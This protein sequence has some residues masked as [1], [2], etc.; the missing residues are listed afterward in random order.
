[1]PKLKEQLDAMVAQEVIKPVDEPTEWCEPI[2]LAGKPNGKIRICVDLSRLKMSG[3]TLPEMHVCYLTRSQWGMSHGFIFIFA[4]KKEEHDETLRE[5][6]GHLKNSGITLNKEKCQFGVSNVTFLG[7]YINEHSIKSDKKKVKAITE[8]KLSADLQGVQHFMGIVNFLG[9]FVPNLAEITKPL[10]DLRKK[11]VLASDRVLA[12]FDISKKTIISA[13]SSSYGLGAVL[14]QEH[15]A[16]EWRPMAFASRTLTKT[17]QGYT[18]IEKEA[19]P[20]TWVCERFKDFVV[21]KNLPHQTDHKPLV[22]IFTTKDLKDLMPRLQRMDLFHYEGSEHLV[23]IDYFSHFIEVVRLTKLSSEA[24]VDHCKAIFAHHGIPDIVISDNGPQFR[25]STISAF[26]K[27]ASEVGFRHITSSPKHP[28]SNGQAE[29]AVKIVKNQMKKNKRSDSPLRNFYLDQKSCTSKL[30]G[31]EEQRKI[32]QKITFDRRQ[33]AMKKAEL[34]AEEKVWVKDL[35]AWGSVIE[36][37]QRPLHTSWKPHETVSS[38]DNE[39]PTEMEE[40]P[41]NE[42]TAEKLQQQTAITPGMKQLSPSPGKVLQIKDKNE[43]NLI[44]EIDH[45]ITENFKEAMDCG[46]RNKW[47][48]AMEEE[49]SDIEKQSNMKPSQL[50]QKLRAIATPDISE[51]LIR[52][53]WLDKLPDSFKAILLVSDEDVNKLAA[54]ADKITD[55]TTKSEIYD[56][57]HDTN[58]VLLDKISELERQISQINLAVEA[59]TNSTAGYIEPCRKYRLFVFDKISKLKFLVDTGADVSI[60]PAT[61]QFKQESDYKLYAAN[62]SK[63]KTFGVKILNLDL[64]LRRDFQWPF[65][66]ANVKRGILGADFLFKYNLLVDINKR[67]LIDGLTNLEIICEAI[68]TFEGSITVKA[69][70]TFNL[71][72]QF[73]DITKPLLFP[74]K[75]NHGVRHRIITKGQPKFAR[76]R[77]LDPRRLESAKQEFEFMLD[78]IIKPSKSQW[79][80]PLHLALKKDGTFRPCGDYRQLN[81]CTLPDRYPIPRIEDVQN[82]L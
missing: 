31:E 51:K 45:Y 68:S 82:I 81:F 56:I 59:A 7:H 42:L 79:A 15:E 10:N 24:V 6:L 78:N 5:V 22:P 34:I 70:S 8:M 38:P 40:T 37:L 29:A 57:N 71:I 4:K 25:P 76:A 60:I 28:Q 74:T 35:R 48:K 17:E 36:K 66:I 53:L 41:G 20:I 52:T 50:L 61:A 32:A 77:Q 12:S 63:I 46:E 2:I 75:L 64:G 1:M 73:P 3:I 11:D 39:L 23:V 47:F 62:G 69:N 43:A 27:F 19:L 44:I 80:S 33:A 49:L 18:Q 72:A 13:N 16:K 21:E 58:K 30:R 26:T 54:M 67:K 9:H 65:I 55:M 14:K